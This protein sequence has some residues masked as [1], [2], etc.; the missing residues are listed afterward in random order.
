ML[1]EEFVPSQFLT[2]TLPQRRALRELP[3]MNAEDVPPSCLRSV[4]VG[5]KG[6]VQLKNFRFRVQINNNAKAN[7]ETKDNLKN[8]IKSIADVVVAGTHTDGGSSS[9][10]KRGGTGV[11]PEG[12][13]TGNNTGNVVHRRSLLGKIS[14]NCD[15]LRK[16]LWVY[17]CLLLA[18]DEPVDV[19]EVIESGNYHE[20]VRMSVEGLLLAAELYAKEQQPLPLQQQSTQLQQPSGQHSHSSSSQLQHQQTSGHSLSQ[21]KQQPKTSNQVS[22]GESSSAS[23]QKGSSSKPSSSTT[24]VP[25][26]IPAA[27]IIH[28]TPHRLLQGTMITTTPNGSSTFRPLPPQSTSFGM[29]TRLSELANQSKKE[30]AKRGPY[31]RDFTKL[32]QIQSQCH[33]ATAFYF[34]TNPYEYLLGLGRWCA[35]CYEEDKTD[36]LHN[37]TRKHGGPIDDDEED[38]EEKKLKSSRGKVKASSGK[39][40]AIEPSLDHLV[41][42]HEWKIMV[43]WTSFI[44]S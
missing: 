38:E 9:S 19:N 29:S 31:K 20:L 4:S 24:I 26:T 28:H 40:K 14:K 10:G 12:V 37:I 13:E 6:I 7:R 18:V 33:P 11:E 1:V 34:Y 23:S 39:P 42:F 44:V 8:G 22:K 2:L 41:K 5:L 3:I 15:T 25:S 43:S 27:S 32:N 16:A 36:Y 30:I 21:L 17:E 35:Y